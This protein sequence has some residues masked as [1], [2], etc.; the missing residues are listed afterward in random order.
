MAATLTDSTRCFDALKLREFISEG[1]LDF[2]QWTSLISDVE[3]I[4]PDDMEKIC[5][6]YENF[7]SNFPLCFGYWRKYAAH[8]ARLSTADKVLEVFEKAVLAATYS[9]GMWVDYCSFSM[10]AF[11]D[12]SDVRR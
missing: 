12:P 10:S 3:K 5:L 1:S 7:L 11:E 2:E 8:M 9:V 4:Y 6:T